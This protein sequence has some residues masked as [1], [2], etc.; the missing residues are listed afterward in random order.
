MKW[1]IYRRYGVTLFVLHQI[2]ELVF[3]IKNYKL[4]YTVQDISLQNLIV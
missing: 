3:H 4:I 2:T 1:D